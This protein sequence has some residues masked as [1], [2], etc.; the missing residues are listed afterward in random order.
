MKKIRAFLNSDTFITGTFFGF[1]LT[2]LAFTFVLTKLYTP[3]N[4]LKHVGFYK[5][6]KHYR[7]V[8][9]SQCRGNREF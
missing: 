4:L 6:G 1:V 8:E 3:N 7:V 2:M 9:S 5:D